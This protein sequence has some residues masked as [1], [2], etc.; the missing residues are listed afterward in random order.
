MEKILAT[1]DI[2]LGKISVSGEDVQRMYTA[3]KLIADARKI[4]NTPAPVQ[5]AGEE[6][7]EA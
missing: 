5:E 6:K 4:L 1:L 2:L 3:R 7:K